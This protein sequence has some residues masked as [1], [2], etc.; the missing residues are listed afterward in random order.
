MSVYRT[1]TCFDILAW[2]GRPAPFPREHLYDSSH[3]KTMDA[4]T[5]HNWGR[6][7][8]HFHILHRRRVQNT[9]HHSGAVPPPTNP[10]TT[11]NTHVKS[12]S[13]KRAYIGIYTRTMQHAARH[14]SSD[15]ATSIISNIDD[16]EQTTA[17]RPPLP[18]SPATVSDFCQPKTRHLQHTVRHA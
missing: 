8:R 12:T 11:T 7:H 6:R 9:Y 18:K 4:S 16:H 15:A 3:S 13:D 2:V 10:K 1:H 14:P 17:E 5:R